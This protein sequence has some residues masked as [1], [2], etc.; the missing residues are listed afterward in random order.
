MRPQQ[1]RGRSFFRIDALETDERCFCRSCCAAD[2][3]RAAAAAARRAAFKE[4]F[5]RIAE[6]I[7]GVK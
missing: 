3:L 1:R 6:Q 5:G 2:P 4:R 7:G